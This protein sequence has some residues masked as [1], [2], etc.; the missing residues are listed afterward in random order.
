MPQVPGLIP[1]VAP[2]S[3]GT[4]DVSLAVPVDAF[5]GAVGKAF[6]GL[7]GAIEGAG[8]KIWQRA[9]DMQN[10]QNET[11]AKQADAKYM[12]ESGKLHADFINKEGLNAGPEALTKHI[13]DLQDLRKSTGEGLNPMAAKMYDASSLSFMGRNIFN[14]AGHSGQQM[15]VAA[16]G[17]ADA[18]I[19]TTSNHIGENPTDDIAFQRGK[20]TIESEIDAKGRN[21]GWTPEQI[22]QTKEATLSTTSAKRIIGLARTDAIGAMSMY[23]SAS[24]AGALTPIDAAK[25][26]AS[27]QGQFRTQGSRII[28]DKVLA[29]RQ[30][31][32]EE[33]PHPVDY[34][35]DKAKA[36]AE[37]VTKKL[38]IDDPL[39]NDFVRN[40]V[41][42]KYK[43]QR[44]VEVDSDNT[45]VRTIGKAMIKAN[46]QGNLPTTIDQLK[47]VDPEV[48]GAWDAIS[49]DPRKQQAIL[50]Q[51]QR[52]ASGAAKVPIT[53]EN[54]QL[55]H[56]YK[57]QSFSPNDDERAAF[58][59]KDFA[60]DPK[61][62]IAQKG[63]L[64]N[65]QDQYRK[66][67]Q[68]D[69]RVGRALRI[70]SPDLAGA[71]IDPK[72]SKDDYHQFTGALADALEQFQTDHPGK[73]PS[74][75]E[76]QT[77][78][79]QIM[80]EQNTRWWQSHQ[81]FYQMT[82]PDEQRDRIK[83][84]PSWDRKGIRPTDAM[85]DRIYRAEEFRKRY[86]GTVSS[87]KTNFPPNAPNQ[88]RPTE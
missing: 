64:M 14:A 80:Q 79:S 52:N 77:L 9:M 76:V 43:Q 53:P 65:L 23:N 78:G 49:R 71:G 47:A 34:Y 88:P 11:Q 20:R 73:M 32:D 25:V 41:M 29:D 67:A 36:E 70:L 81:G 19:E 33:D 1:T 42:T 58:M 50:S 61:L 68:D 63:A 45:N 16:N 46:A 13:Q 21:S 57:G 74:K 38:G 18:R 26:E 15:K 48:S 24:K 56:T 87:D 66:Q 7:G 8:D 59:A 51:L 44:A 69:P 22:Q 5:G 12:M 37:A 39:F 54:L 27:V 86:G 55:F 30:A 83:A 10:L 75:E 4:P 6:E 60:N 84:D 28:A 2:S 82:A 85:I 35:L 40:N 72:T 31:G 3:G 62:A 17:A